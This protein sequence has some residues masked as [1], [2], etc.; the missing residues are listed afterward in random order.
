MTILD[1]GQS[2]PS[3]GGPSFS[4][5]NRLRR[6]IW[7]ASWGLLA[8][9]TPPAAHPWR[10]FLLRLFGAKIH[11]TAVIYASARIWYPPHLEMEAFSCLGPRV[12]CYCMAPITLRRHA[13]ISQG[14]HLCTGTHDIKDPDFQLIARP[15]EVGAHGW[16][17]AEAFVGPGVIIGEGAVLGAR[18]VAF[19]TLPPWSV[20]LGN[21]ARI[22][23]ARRH[24]AAPGP[25][26]Q[27]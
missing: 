16:V 24:P 20:S 3:E 15:I 12:T 25:S 9:W 21:P 14:A 19:E 6:A 2:R 8:A 18:G 7:T 26:D 13:V 1:A 5:G 10:R 27:R 4:L 17:A 22:V 11:P 23:K